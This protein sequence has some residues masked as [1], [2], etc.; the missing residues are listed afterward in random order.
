MRLMIVQSLLLAALAKGHMLAD[1]IPE[2]LGVATRA[3]GLA[4]EHRE[5]SY[6]AWTLLLLGDKMVG[7]SAAEQM[8]RA[9]KRFERITPSDLKR[10]PRETESGRSSGN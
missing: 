9:W 1:R 8:R 5:P 7:F 10:C 2:R 6:E 4:R 3:L